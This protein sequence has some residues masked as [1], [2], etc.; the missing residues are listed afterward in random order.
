MSDEERGIRRTLNI[1][2]EWFFRRAKKDNKQTK[3][4]GYVR[5]GQKSRAN[6]NKNNK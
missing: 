3:T 5:L 2:H 6:K 1:Q 4:K